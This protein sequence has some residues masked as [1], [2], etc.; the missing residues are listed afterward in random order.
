MMAATTKRLHKD[1]MN[2]QFEG[3]LTARAM[4]IPGGVLD[5]TK[6]PACK[7]DKHIGR[8]CG[9]EVD[10]TVTD[11]GVEP[12]RCPCHEEA[13]KASTGKCKGFHLLPWDALEELARVYEYGAK[14]YAPN[15]WRD[16]PNA[17]EEYTNA[18]FRHIRA[19]AEGRVWD[20]EAAVLGY[21]IRHQSMVLWNA[22]AVTALTQKRDIVP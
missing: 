21:R 12:I 4:L 18:M 6:C 17:I 20:E 5:L 8:V 10:V 16:V 15:S 9:T 2:A 14:K 11:A 13:R 7:H 22:A 3:P 1:A 19:V